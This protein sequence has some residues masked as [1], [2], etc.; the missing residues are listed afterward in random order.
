MVELCADDPLLQAG[1]L[2][3]T[4][5]VEDGEQT[6][7]DA[8]GA[9]HIRD[10]LGVHGATELGAVVED[11]D[12][13]VV[14]LH[15]QDG[16]DGVVARA[17]EVVAAATLVVAVESR[18]HALVTGSKNLEDVELAAAGGPA[19]ALGVTVLESAGDLSVEHPDGGHVDG[20][21]DVG[22][23]LAI[24]GHL[25]LE[26]EGLLGTTETVV[27]DSARTSVATAVTLALLVG[28]DNNLVGRANLAVLE[29]LGG[30]AATLS[31]AAG[32]G[33]RVTE[34][35]VEDTGAGATVVVQE[36]ETISIAGLG[37][38]VSLT[39]PVA[40]GGGRAKKAVKKATG[41]LG[42]RSR[43]GGGVRGRSSVRGGRGGGSLGAGVGTGV[44]H[45]LD[46]RGGRRSSGSAAVGVGPAD[47][48]AIDGGVDHVAHFG[49]TLVGVSV[50]MGV[51]A[52]GGGA[53]LGLAG[54]RA[55]RGVDGELLQLGGATNVHGHLE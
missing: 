31:V 10:G 29:D 30:R 20:V 49:F 43:R 7:E 39:V 26:E 15:D 32:V 54:G 35:V 53:A 41:R 42:G 27:S 34:G 5:K 1:R 55:A 23:G 51:T 16:L 6:V 14:V 48:L 25:E 50:R 11:L 46:L 28:H 47:G 8:V 12:V 36:N 44:G 3:V 21:V 24:V 33:E 37:V 45:V 38:V 4:G 13:D 22:A 9:A 18:L 19:R 40:T 17:V 2:V 52:S